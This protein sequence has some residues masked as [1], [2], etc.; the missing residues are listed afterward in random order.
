MR[1]R[2][3][4]GLQHPRVPSC[5]RRWCLMV[6]GSVMMTRASSTASCILRHCCSARTPVCGAAAAPIATI[7]CLWIETMQLT[8]PYLR[9]ERARAAHV[10]LARGRRQQRRAPLQV[11]VRPRG[12]HGAGLWVRLVAGAG[13]RP[14]AAGGGARERRRWRRATARHGAAAAAVLLLLL[15][16]GNALPRAWARFGRSHAECEA[17]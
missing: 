11:A 1:A 9:N 4:R 8:K 6:S 12:L 7:A 2:I 15:L 3:A 10:L 13:R 17:L 14:R 16:L 5:R